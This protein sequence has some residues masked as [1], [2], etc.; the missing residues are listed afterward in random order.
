MKTSIY[1]VLLITLILSSCRK[2]KAI[3][4]D[5]E[6]NMPEFPEWVVYNKGNSNLKDNQIN[7][8][9]I[10]KNDVK[11]LGTANGLIRI[12]AES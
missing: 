7:A 6:I 1:S 10:D 2:D 4:P 9:S 3:V 5:E 8:F 12:N 11:W